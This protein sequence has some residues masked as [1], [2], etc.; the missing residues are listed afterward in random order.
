MKA[1]FFVLMFSSLAHAQGRAP[2]DP[3]YASCMLTIGSL[4]SVSGSP[5]Y[6][7]LRW[8]IEALAFAQE[9]VT[10]MEHGLEEFK[11][12]D[13]P[14]LA[15]S[16]IITSHNEGRDYLW[17]AA[18]VMDRYKPTADDDRLIKRLLV[19]GYNQEA[20]VAID[21][22]ADMKKQYLGTGQQTKAA[23]LKHAEHLSA[24]HALQME[25][26]ESLVEMTTMSLML[27]VDLSDVKA[28]NTAK[29]LMSCEEFK[30]LRTRS[31]ALMKRED[32]IYRQNA[33]LFLKFIDGHECKR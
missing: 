13:T 10:T 29:T 23:T 28:K 14:S 12:A 2:T 30:D 20:Q 3:I 4:S 8:E 26:G 27:A 17:C 6:L 22:L 33:S 19:Q 15:L 9:S 32:S 25:A 24:I 11:A 21:V 31:D 1:W 7:R 5:S 18:A 16:S